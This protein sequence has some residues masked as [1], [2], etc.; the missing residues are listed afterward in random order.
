MTASALKDTLRAVGET[1]PEPTRIRI[2]RAI[3]WLARAEA[4]DDNPDARFLFL[5]IAFNAAYARE[6][7]KELTE[8]DQLNAYFGALLALDGKW[9]LHAVLFRE[10]SGA[11]RTL[12]ENKFVF[13]PFWRAFREHDGS[14]GWDQ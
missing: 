7:G 3:S 11:I 6:F 12:I 1:M 13:E 2:H 5:W 14:G 9:P 10:F 4:E 8:R